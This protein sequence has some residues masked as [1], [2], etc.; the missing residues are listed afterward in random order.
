GTVITK[1]DGSS[2]AGVALGVVHELNVPIVYVGIGESI[3]DLR[4]FNA[5]SFIEAII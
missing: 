1:M 3:E 2:K 5:D 4:E